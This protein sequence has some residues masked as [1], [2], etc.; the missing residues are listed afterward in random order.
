MQVIAAWLHFCSVA[1]YWLEVAEH[2]DLLVFPRAHTGHGSHNHA[3][4]CKAPKGMYF[5]FQ[6]S[7]EDS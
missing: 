7:H 6:V 5:M 2:N 1:V 3:V 4:V